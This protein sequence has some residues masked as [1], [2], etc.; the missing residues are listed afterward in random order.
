MKDADKKKLL[1]SPLQAL[2][3]EPDPFI[4]QASKVQLALYQLFYAHGLTSPWGNPWKVSFLLGHPKGGSG[5]G[6]YAERGEYVLFSRDA[7]KLLT[8]VQWLQEAFNNGKGKIE[9]RACCPLAEYR[10]CV[11]EV[12]FQCPIHNS[13]C[14]GTHD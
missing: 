4:E 12:S 9:P 3:K 10:N 6:F 2:L 13:T 1:D 5:H 14:I 7:H 8:Y 11:C